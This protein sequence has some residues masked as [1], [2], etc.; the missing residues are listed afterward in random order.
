MLFFTAV[1]S[2]GKRFLFAICVLLFEVDTCDLFR[3]QDM[4]YLDGAHM[5]GNCFGILEIDT[6]A[7]AH[8][9]RWQ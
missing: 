3:K 2:L 7:K 1:L 5:Q 6:G 4:S 9:P 8:G